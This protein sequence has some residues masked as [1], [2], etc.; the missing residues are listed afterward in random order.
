MKTWILLG[1]LAALLMTLVLVPAHVTLAQGGSIVCYA[2][3]MSPASLPNST[4][5]ASYSQTFHTTANWDCCATPPFQFWIS[6]GSLPTGL[7]LS[8]GGLLSGVTVAP[9]TYTFTVYTTDA[10]GGATV[11]HC[12][13]NYTVVVSGINSPPTFTPGGDVTVFEGA[14]PYA[15]HWT[16]NISPGG[17]ADFGQTVTFHVSNDNNALFSMQPA[18][19][20]YGNLYFIVAPN[21]TGTANLTVY[22][23][24]NGG[25]ANGG[26]DTSTTATFKI[27]VVSG[28]NSPPTFTPGGDVTVLEDA[29][30]YSAAWASGISVGGTTLAELSQTIS[31]HISN[32]NNALFSVQPAIA[33]DGILSFTVAPDAYGTANVSF[34]LTDNGGTANGGSDTSTTATF[35]ITVTVVD[36]VQAGPTYTV[37]STTWATDGAC[38]ESNCTLR[39]ALE[40]AND[41]GVDSTIELAAGAVYEIQ[42]VDN[43]SVNTGPT[44]LPQITTPITING[45]GAQIKRSDTAP[46]ARLF[47]VAGGFLTLNEIAL[48]NGKL[49]PSVDSS[50]GGAILDGG[51]LVVRNSYLANNAAKY[52]GAIYN[53][54]GPAA[55]IYNSTFYANS[56]RDG[57]IRSYG[58]LDLYSNT[59]F[60]NIGVTESAIA[61]G[62]TSITKY[63]FYNNL[64]VSSGSSV[65]LCHLTVPGT[66]ITVGGNLATDSSCTGFGLT[67]YS[68]VKAVAP[69]DH[70]GGLTRNIAIQLGSSAIDGGN[71]TACQNTNIDGR[72]QRGRTRF[73]DGNGDG[74]AQ[75]DVGAFEYSAVQLPPPSQPETDPP[76]VAIRLDPPEPDGSHGWY[77]SA[78]ALQPQAS[79]ASPVIELRCALDPQRAPTTYDD[80]PQDLCPFLSGAPV[81]ADGEHTFY[82]AAMDIWGNKSVPV[83]AGF[84]VDATS[85][86]ITCPSAGPF[87]L[88]SGNQPVG[89]AGVDAAVSGLDEAASTLSGFVSTESVGP[90]TVTFTATD[91]AGNAASQQC[92][93][94]VVYDFGGFYPPVEP[95]PTLNETQAGS[96]VP[97]KFSLAGDQGLGVIA[98]GHPVSQQVA[99]DEYKPAGSPEATK[100]ANN[101]GL[102][103]NPDNG[104][105]GYVW[106]TDKGWAGTCRALTIKL[107]DGTEH[108]AF[109]QFK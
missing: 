38:T 5:G 1:L 75:C 23:T 14:S 71:A 59:F 81:S 33:L 48:E 91:L 46:Y 43:T 94:N 106:K 99:C 49:D 105:Y 82:A 102:S 18:I 19:D 9:G 53:P 8:S 2:L 40:A 7:T 58:S 100:P 35:K 78:V 95:S 13:G 88:H 60:D 104:W 28:I 37:N 62:Y 103:Y 67:T 55:W 57:A 73:A 52:G 42:G 29:P 80:L 17:P 15:L 36:D 3:T 107:I 83:S 84:R 10:Y 101:N 77:R 4:M 41:D 56:A 85:P 76:Q 16:S 32:D 79:D 25:T 63:N 93:Y 51:R 6:S 34:Y 109:F 89:P 21:A 86:V 72:D 108:Q 22:L 96:A 44:G 74:V 64:F 20:P 68:A 45:H 70:N 87:L 30:P 97:L 61:L 12:E 50:V 47:D 54:G 39:E 92:S 65:P 24:D 31:P 26:H 66:I 27:N 11:Y 90:K 98:Q 69:P